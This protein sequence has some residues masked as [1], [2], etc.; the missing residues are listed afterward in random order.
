MRR[1]DESK[2]PWG[3]YDILRREPG[4]Q[5]KRIEV[6][7]GKRFS[8]QKHQKRSERWIVIAGAGLATVGQKEIPV[9][10]GSFLD[11]PIGEIH[12]LENTG[13]SPLIFIEVQFGDYLAEDDIVRL[14][15][16]FGRS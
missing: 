4:I 16:D 13:K 14:Q 9:G 3:R 6:D 8:L 5:V 11:I 7:P 12:R 15:D 1:V 10:K 2:R